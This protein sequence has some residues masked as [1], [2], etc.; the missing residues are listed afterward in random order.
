MPD[1]QSSLPSAG[2]FHFLAIAAFLQNRLF[3]ITQPHQLLD[4]ASPQK[5]SQFITCQAVV[6]CIELPRTVEFCLFVHE[7]SQKFN[8]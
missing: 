3:S 1:Q 5:G 2:I 6:L 7:C 8:S 4:S